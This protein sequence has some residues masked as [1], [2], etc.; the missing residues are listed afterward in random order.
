MEFMVVCCFTVLW[1]EFIG[2]LESHRYM[3]ST[4]PRQKK[5]LNFFVFGK[6]YLSSQGLIEWLS[7]TMKRL[8]FLKFKLGKLAN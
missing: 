5:K 6:V 4:A 1:Q 8:H 2:A 7:E 3:L